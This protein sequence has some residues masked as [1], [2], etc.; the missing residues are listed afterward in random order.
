VKTTN[1]QPT[2]TKAAVK[3]AARNNR[4][5][6]ATE[7]RSTT[8]TTAERAANPYATQ[9]DASTERT[10]RASLSQAGSAARAQAAQMQTE[11]GELRRQA[12]A[13]QESDNPDAAA[14]LLAEA[15]RLEANAEKRLKAAATYDAV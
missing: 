7:Q 1:T 14:P 11:A 9:A 13:W 2:A 4:K 10:F 3:M 5:A 8:M 12:A 6:A 15:A